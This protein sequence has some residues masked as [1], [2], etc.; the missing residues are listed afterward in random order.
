VQTIILNIFSS[1]E[2]RSNFF[3][4]LLRIL[5]TASLCVSTALAQ[6][7]KPYFRSIGTEHGLSHAKVNCILQDKRGFL[8]FGTE[9]GL[10]RYDGRSFTVF[11][12]Q[13]NDTASISGNIITDLYEDKDG[14]M[15]IAT[16]DGGLT[17]YN[18]RLHAT[19]QFKQYRHDPK[20]PDGI[21]ENRINKIADDGNGNLWLATSNS[22]VV[23]FIKKHSK[24]ERPYKKGTRSILTLSMVN[25]NTLWVG[26]AGGGLLKINTQT[27]AATAD[28]RYNDL[29]AKL[30]HAAI[31][32]VFKDSR[33]RI[34][35]GAWDKTLY[36]YQQGMR[37]KTVYKRNRNNPGVPQDEIVSF[38][39][40][41]QNRVWMASK[42]SGVAIFDPLIRKFSTYQ[43]NE[44]EGSLADNHVNAVYTD[45]TGIV[46]IGTDNGI[47]AFDPVYSPFQK[48]FLPRE[49]NGKDITIYDFYRD[50]NRDLWVGTSNGIYIKRQGKKEFEH[51]KLSFKGEYLA[52]TKF[53]IDKDHTFYLGTDYSLF[54]YDQRTNK[55]S[56]LP[57]TA[58]D[59]VMKKLISSRITSIVRDTIDNHPVLIISPYGH[60]LTYYDLTAQK[61][62][63]RSDNRKKIIKRLNI[64]DNLIKKFHQDKRGNIWIATDRF[65]LG[66]WQEPAAPIQ[67]FVNERNNKGSINSNDVFDIEEDK[68]GN[69][70]V[71]TYGGGLHYFNTKSFHF[72]HIKGSSNL[73][74]GLQIDQHG[75][76]WMICNGHLHA[77]NPLN[78]IYSCYDLPELQNSGGVK[79]YIYQDYEGMLYAAG[80]NYF[81]AFNPAIIS[82]ISSQPDVYFTDFKIFNKSYSHLLEQKE[83][84][85]NHEQNYFS[86]EFSA[87]EYNSNHIQYEYM[88][89][90]FDKDWVVT[91]G[92]TF[93]SYSN[94]RG[95]K[96]VFKVKASNWDGN[97][98]NK[99]AGL[100]AV[101]V[102]C[103]FDFYNRS[104]LLHALPLQD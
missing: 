71:S 6:D 33:K 80:L 24:F 34:W 10:N 44:R 1:Q 59:V 22:Y 36:S 43:H 86:I 37:L 55:V 17:R 78:K 87:P 48:I 12:N 85:L 73:T 92:R 94:L 45:R 4:W 31:T 15:W 8:W 91:A 82:K 63:S 61:W 29:Y 99:Y 42:Q 98:V 74:E 40:D 25:S 57:N 47:S 103:D 3:N 67:Y 5:F 9:D 104:C 51:K 60:Y 56:L 72:N 76:V 65:G 35:F 26:R 68:L 66:I 20:N 62:V 14:V 70:W 21:P 11:R 83:I 95:G 102:L 88:L 13:P 89:E 54:K 16:A 93:A 90:G 32:S 30:P 69:L 84:R 19:Q 7:S 81:I 77:Y 49:P 38:A 58:S 53:F 50:E 28:Y 39:E 79:G 96:Y 52:A 75:S 46:W 64:K 101:V 23:K 97:N 27:S 18:Y 2:T 100:S 41:K